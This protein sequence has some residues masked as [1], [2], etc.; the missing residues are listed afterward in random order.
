MSSFVNI[1]KRKIAYSDVGKGTPI[2]FLHGWMD[3]R[4]VYKEIIALLSKKYRCVSID[5]PGFGD[6]DSLKK[7]TIENVSLIL[8]KFV[9]RLKLNKFYMVGHSLGGAVSLIYAKKHEDRII[10]MVLIAPFIKYSQFPKLT[11]LIIRHLAPYLINKKIITPIFKLVKLT[12]KIVEDRKFDINY[13]KRLKKQRVRRKAINALKYAYML[14]SLDLYSALAKIR[15][16]V[17][18]VYGSKDS[19]LKLKPLEPLFGI[20]NNIHLVIFEN[21]RHYIYSFD[22]E[23][24]TQKI[25]LFFKRSSGYN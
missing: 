22:S 4:S 15:K 1:N 25:D 20:I 8:H 23:N 13:L 5:L 19:F 9:R 16:D 21:V 10:K 2:V 12:N 14:N 6:S 11:F 18:L 7:L 24:L 3:S 17:L